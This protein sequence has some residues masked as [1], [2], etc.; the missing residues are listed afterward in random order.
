MD[1]VAIFCRQIRARSH[2]HRQA[3]AALHRLPGQMISVLRQELDSLVRVIFLLAQ[4]DRAYRA[5]LIHASTSGQ[6]WTKSNSRKRITDR[7]MV[8]LAQALHGWSKS[9]YE[10]GCAFIHLSHLHDYRTRDAL[11]SLPVAEQKSILVHLRNYHGGPSEPNPTFD[12]IVPYLP[13]VFEKI[14]DNLECYL[15]QLEKDE[16]LEVEAV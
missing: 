3:M 12:H 10:F 4:K 16:D 15:E 8:D 9:V 2:E 14:A 7:E 11:R 6:R 5:K 13:R 1:E